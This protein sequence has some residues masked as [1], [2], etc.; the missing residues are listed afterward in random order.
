MIPITP[1]EITFK[2]KTEEE[3]EELEDNIRNAIKNSTTE[4]EKREDS[5]LPD[6]IKSLIRKKIKN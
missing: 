4:T 2:G 6:N 1:R 3:I 5:Q